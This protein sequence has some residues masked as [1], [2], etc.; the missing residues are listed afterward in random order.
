MATDDSDSECI[1]NDTHTG[2]QVSLNSLYS[3][4]AQDFLTVQ[5]C[6]NWLMLNLTETVMEI[7]SKTLSKQFMN[8]Q[9]HV[10][11]VVYVYIIF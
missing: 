5:F 7:K 11:E 2:T 4:H 6:R 8:T 9:S 3:V 10:R 1:V